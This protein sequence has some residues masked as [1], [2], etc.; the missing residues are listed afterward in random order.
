MLERLRVVA[1]DPRSRFVAVGAVNTLVGYV[2]Y[3]A[4]SLWVFDEL[5][6][7][8][9]ISLVLSYVVGIVIAF[10]LYRRFVFHVEGN[11]LVDFIRFVGVYVV[12]IALNLVVL[13]LLVEIVGL[14]PVVAQLY[15]IA[16]TTV[17]SYV[18]H[19]GFSF[20]RK[21]GAAD[22]PGETRADFIDSA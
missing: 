13:P 3:S 1:D 2:V 20:R 6:L 11:V 7:G 22:P 4:L 21:V 8:Y 10:F 14:S 9:L 18:G 17:V 5:R 15:A 12:S 16:L 19:K